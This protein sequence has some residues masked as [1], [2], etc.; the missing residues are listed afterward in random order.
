[1]GRSTRIFIAASATLVACLFSAALAGSQAPP[2]PRPPMAEEVFKNIQVL[3]GI[4][5]DQFMGT[6]GFF[7]SA[8]GL[9]CTDC[10]VDESGG[11][12]ARYADDNALKQQT[13]RMVVMMNTI[14]R[15][16]FGGRQV[17]TCNTCHRGSSRPNVMPSINALYG[18]PPPDE[19][20]DPF[21]QAAGQPPPDQ[22]LDKYLAAVGG[23][24]RLAALTSLTAKGTY[25]GFDDADKSAME[26]F[27]R[28]PGERTTIVHTL[29][30]D[31]T[32]TIAG[33]TGWIAAPPTDKPVPL[34]WIT[35]Q[36]LEGVRLEAELFFP[37]RIKQALT[38]WRTG[39]PALL[40]DREVVTVQGDTASG[41]VATLC[42]DAET[43]LLVRLVRY[44]ESPVGRL[45]TRVDYHEYRDVA[46]VKIPSRWTVSWLSGRSVFELTDVQPNAQVPPARFARPAL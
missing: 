3:K 6:M 37:A 32:T 7:A 43:G 21:A 20:G 13:R 34:M 38:K 45:V 9:N 8:T 2:A 1:M 12:W 17:V 5:V 27:A 14:N 18:E 24:Q 15:T 46:G 40:G 23:P 31:S 41:G 19:P 35:G 33:G 26:I 4:P 42:F 30:G 25:M 29:L 10:H 39:L 16:N 28:A 22:V 36:E 11:S 44:T